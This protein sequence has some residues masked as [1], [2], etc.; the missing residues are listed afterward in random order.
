VFLSALAT[1]GPA[2]AALQWEDAEPQFS[3]IVG[4]GTGDVEAGLGTFVSYA[5]DPAAPP[6]TG[7]VFYGR[8]VAAVTGNSCA[9][10]AVRFEVTPPPGAS[11][12]I[13]AA[14]PV[15]CLTRELG[16]ESTAIA[17]SRCPQVVSPPIYGGAA[18]FDPA[19]QGSDPTWDIARRQVIEIQFPMVA[20]NPLLGNGAFPCHCLRGFTKVIDT[21]ENPILKPQVPVVVNA[22]AAPVAPPPAPAAAPAPPPPAVASPVAVKRRPAGKC[23]KLKGK[24]RTA[25]IKKA[26]PKKLKGKKKA[27]CVKKVTRKAS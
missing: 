22:G 1:A 16:G 11:I 14:H 4:C 8:T 13:S 6:K 12:A 23:A 18:A 17:P 5:Y 10:H 24:K 20:G 3:V 21:A 15:Y 25:C 2:S 19:D 26:C 9:G 27:A 7:E